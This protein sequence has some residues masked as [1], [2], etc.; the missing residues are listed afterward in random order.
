MF[1]R[2]ILQVM[3]ENKSNYHNF[4]AFGERDHF[5][6]PMARSTVVRNAKTILSPSDQH[7]ALLNNL[8]FL[9]KD[10]TFKPLNILNSQK[11]R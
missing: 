5:E 10:Q 11:E 7:H 6:I 3:G 9:Y 1:N 8:T 4:T 2:I